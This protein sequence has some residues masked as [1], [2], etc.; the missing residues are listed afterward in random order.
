MEKIR[1][2]ACALIIENDAILLVEFKNDNDDGVHYNLPAGG[3]GPGET[4]I[5]AAQREAK[6]ETCVEVK[7][8]PVAFVYEYQPTKNNY[9][10][11]DTHSVGVTFRCKL[12]SGSLPK[13]PENP[14]PHQIGV[15]WIPISE[16]HSIQLYPEI[17]KDIVDYFSGENY[18]N[19][20]EE[21]E[22][23]LSKSLC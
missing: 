1:L 14:D 16:L 19:Y 12:K 7:V 3:L 5:E 9:I 21:H 10:Y 2:R 4:L 23:Q 11:G 18:R 6:E 8:G 20:V 15:K 22:I 13:L 17:N